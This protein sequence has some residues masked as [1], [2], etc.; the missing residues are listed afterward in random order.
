MG[1]MRAPSSWPWPARL[2]N[3]LG[4]PLARR[5]LPTV[6]ALLDRARRAT[7]LHDF[8]ALDV[9]TPLGLILAD[10][11]EARLH[12]IG[13]SA[14]LG[15]LDTLLITRLEIVADLAAHPEIAATPIA[16]PIVIVG[17]PRTGTTLLHRLLAQDPALRWMSLGETVYPEL[18]G[19]T[20]AVRRRR[21]QRLRALGLSLRAWHY[22]DP[23]LAMKHAIAI[24]EPDEEN[25]ALLRS[26][27][28]PLLCEWGEMPR[29][30]RWLFGLGA[31]AWTPIYRH[32]RSELQLGTHARPG[33]WLLK[34]PSHVFGVAGLLEV[35][36]DVHVIAT[37]RD[38]GAAL[39]S[40]CS[41]ELT[42]RRL[43]GE[44]DPAGVR[45]LGRTNL[46]QAHEALT[47][48]ASARARLPAAQLHDVDYRDLVADPIAVARGLYRRLDLRW[49]AALE[50][51]LRAFMARHPQHQRGRHTYDA[52]TFGLS[53]ADTDALN[54]RS[55]V[56]L[57]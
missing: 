51:R 23:A 2:V 41:L 45:A 52:H 35:F 55:P 36:P 30:T 56:P 5:P 11:A 3:R 24:D 19:A 18:A 14:A 48:M 39:P 49:T 17:Q 21:R 53:T 34:S 28:C 4:A 27:A 57:G 16:R 13:R 10:L 31:P 37:H 38:F 40:L 26:L 50:A 43:H 29:Y 9:E 54:A 33:H 32:L 7:G 22:I 47:R 1:V 25:P 15:M 6:A 46:A 44:V 20:A 8:G 42:C 12:A